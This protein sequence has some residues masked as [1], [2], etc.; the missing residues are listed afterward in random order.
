MAKSKLAVPLD[1]LSAMVFGD[2]AVKITAVSPIGGDSVDLLIEGEGV[3]D[4]E[5]ISG[6]TVSTRQYIA[7][8][9][10]A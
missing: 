8:D 10:P 4:V 3:A 5:R 6:L 2:V 7:L 9:S 1:L